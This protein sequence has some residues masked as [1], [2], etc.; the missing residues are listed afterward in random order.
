MYEQRL[1]GTK[2]ENLLHFL[3]IMLESDSFN[4]SWLQFLFHFI[5]HITP[6]LPSHTESLLFSLSLEN[7]NEHIGIGQNKMKRA[8]DKAQETETQWMAHSGIS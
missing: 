1:W 2:E 4:I 8:Q 3:N 6:H 7:K 5:L